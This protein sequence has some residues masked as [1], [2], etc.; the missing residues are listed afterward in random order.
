MTIT[1]KIC[2]KNPWDKRQRYILSGIIWD[3]Y[4]GANNQVDVFY[5][6]DGMRITCT[7]EEFQKLILE[8]RDCELDFTIK[9]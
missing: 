4:F 2:L 1:R 3:Y 7:E 6:W 5:I 8:C 9:M